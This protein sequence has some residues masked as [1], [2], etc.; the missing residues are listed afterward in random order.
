V[1]IQGSRVKLGKYTNLVYAAVD[2][3]AHRDVYKPIAPSHWNLQIMPYDHIMITNKA[4][5]STKAK[6]SSSTIINSISLTVIELI[7][8]TCI[9]IFLQLVLLFFW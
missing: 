5:N 3:I 6:G 4:D 2:A 9:S 7:N 1:S 8:Y